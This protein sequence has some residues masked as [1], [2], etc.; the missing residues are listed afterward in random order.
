MKNPREARK[1]D[2]GASDSF[3]QTPCLWFGSEWLPAAGGPFSRWRLRTRTLTDNQLSMRSRTLRRLAAVVGVSLFVQGASAQYPSRTID[4]SGNNQADPTMGAAF[5]YLKRATAVGYDD[6]YSVPAG[7]TRPSAR[8][9]SNMVSAQAGAMPNA[10]G[11]SDMLWQWGQFLDHDIDLTESAKPAESFDIQVP[12]G[13][14][15]F[16]PTFTGT[17]VIPLSRS[18]YGLDADGVRQQINEIT[19]WIDASMVY[20]SDQARALE[21]R[22]LDGTG[23]LKTQATAVGELLP[24]NVNGLPNAPTSMDPTLFLAGDVRANEQ[25]G[26]TALHTLFV[27][28]H[29]ALATLIYFTF[30][31]L[32][33]DQIYEFVRMMVGAEI[34]AITYNEFLPAL[35]GEYAIPAYRGYDAAVDG[36]IMNEFSGAAFRFGHTM[37][38]PQLMRLDGGMQTIPDGHI[39]LRDAFFNPDEILTLGIEPLL[40]GLSAQPAQA[41]DTR[42][43]DDVRNFLF[44]PPGAGG[45][46]LASLNMQRG[47]DHGLVDYNSMREE[48]GLPRF[49]TF[50]EFGDDFLAWIGL[51]FLYSD[52]DNVDPW[53]GMLTE[54]KAPFSQLGGL[55]HVIV[56]E[57][58]T[59]LR[60]GDRYWYQNVLSGALQRWVNTQTLAVIIRRN[61]TIGFE[62][63]DDVFR[64]K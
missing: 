49:A 21:L 16:D 43:I 61:T 48:F 33:G 54:D 24:F 5:T 55:A 7:P 17:Q 47:R 2:S 30:P 4:G 58:F 6:G 9:I 51:G 50:G 52:I 34:Q 19:A 12:P 38:P 13:D 31:T 11:L 18:L 22:T 27:R 62:I 53:I 35:L 37:L 14:P 64:V 32:G 41:I 20:G 23:R 46:D 25:N 26:L 3:G 36:S 8:A 57:Q 60:D 39:A 56:A 45:F 15:F 10:A 42:V 29:N 28:E 63:P 1:R 44:G 40:R 59:K